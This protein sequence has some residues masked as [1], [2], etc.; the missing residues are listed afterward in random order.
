MKQTE[1][2]EILESHKLWLETNGKSG[3]RANLAGVD[4]RRANL[5]YV[6][7]KHVNLSYSNLEAVDLA[8]SNL[9]GANLAFSNLEDSNLVGVNLTD[10][11]GKEIIT[12]QAGKHFAYY[13]DNLIK[14]GCETHNVQFWLKNYK[15]IAAFHCYSKQNTKDY[16]NFIK[17]IAKRRKL[18]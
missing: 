13:C 6:D 16:G 5:R 2:N 1:L 12:L 17:F 9:E 14:I 11:Y 8:F 15:E 10:I 7:L 18:C 4:L 3:E